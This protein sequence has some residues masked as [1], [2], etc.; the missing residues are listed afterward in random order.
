MKN[1]NVIIHVYVDEH[2]KD[3]AP[4]IVKFKINKSSL[5]VRNQFNFIIDDIYS[6]H[7]VYIRTMLRKLDP[8][9][10]VAAIQVDAI[11]PQ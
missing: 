10:H 6:V 9:L 11:L 8:E 1:F 7:V 2:Y 4:F 5:P 3:I